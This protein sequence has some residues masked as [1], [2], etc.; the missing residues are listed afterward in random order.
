MTSS[1]ADTRLG[2]DP[3]RIDADLQAFADLTEPDS[4]PGVTRLAYTTLE[5]HAHQ[6]FTDAMGELGL[7]V[8][9]DAAGNTIAELPG[10]NP[11]A[12]AIGTGSH[13][14]S[15]PQGGR[16]DGIAGVV[17]AMEVARL[18]VEHQVKHT[19]AMRF[20]VFAAEE[21]ARFGQAMTGSRIIAGLTGPDDL[22]CLQ[23]GNQITMADAMRE[24]GIDP[25]RVG[26]ARWHPADWAAFVELHVEQGGVLEAAHIP[27]GVVDMISG[28]T[29]MMLRITGRASHSGATP[30]H[31]RA[32]ALA[33]AAEVVLQIES[34]VQDTRHRGARATVGTMSVRPGSLTTI[35]GEVELS[36]DVRDVDSDRQRQI[37]AEIVQ[38]ALAICRR[39]GVELHTEPVADASPVILP[40]WVRDTVADSAARLGVDFRVQPSGASHDSQMIN[41]LV[42]A[43]M[44]FVPSKDG[45]SHAPQERTS[46]ADLVLGTDVL[47]ES[48]LA[49]DRTLTG[50]TEQ[51]P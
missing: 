43:G 37:A 26:E 25:A 30:M 34:I 36:V 12:P 22:T 28:S 6:R 39:R 8:R 3:R 41:T 40:A 13:L 21:G 44:I 16:F 5:R 49:L 42:P 18:Y 23:D 48:L 38:Q 35:P 14:D 17:A 51:S 20:V 19:H 45:I 50:R 2:A 46:T 7:R 47:A 27:I 24:V 1:V 33:A 15:V 31:L 9:T 32:D 11:H 10:A 4:G 29:R